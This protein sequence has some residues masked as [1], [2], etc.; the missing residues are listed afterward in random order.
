MKKFTAIVCLIFALVMA[1]ALPV[2]A[3]SPY[4]TY[5]YSISGKALHSPDAYTPDKTVDSMGM[6]LDDLDFIG[7]YYP[8]LY[9]LQDTITAC[10]I[11]AEKEQAKFYAAW[12]KDSSQYP[13]SEAV[14]YEEFK[15]AQDSLNKALD[16]VKKAKT[17]YKTAMDTYGK[18][19]GPSD[20]EVDDNDNVYI[21]DTTNNRIVVLDRY[22]KAKYIITSFINAQGTMDALKTP[23]G[24]FI[25]SDKYVAGELVPGKIY[26]CDSGN[27][28]IVTFNRNGE[29]LEIIPQPE[30]EL[31]G[32]DSVYTP[33]AVAV[34]NY[35]RLYVVSS[36]STDGIIV[37]TDEGEFT[38]FVGAQKVTVSAWE[39]LWE[40]FQTEA[41]KEQDAQKV[42]SAFNNITLTGDFIYVTTSSIHPE[43]VTSAIDS[44]STSGDYAPVKMLNAAGDE[45][46]RR[47]GFYPPSGEVDH[48][49]RKASNTIF[50]ASTVVDVAI[51]P[52]KTWSI[53]DQKRSKVF[54]YDFDGN[55]LFAFGDMGAESQMQLGNIPNQA[56]AGIVYQG[57]KML[58]LNK[59]DNNFTVY[60]RT[61]Y[62]NILIRALANQNA[63]QNDKAIE[64]WTEILKRNSNFDAA[65]IGIGKALYRSGDYEES[66]EYFKSAY[67]TANYSES[68]KEIRKEW[69]S[70]FIILVPIF[71]VV[72]CIGLAKFFGFAKK[73]N[74]R[75]SVTKGKRT[76]A[77][78]LM[79][80]F[81]VMFHPFDGF[82]DLK[83]EKRGSARAG[84][85][86]LGVTVVAF[87]YQSLGKGYIM[88]ARGTYMTFFGAV[89]AV[90]VPLALWI[91][92]NWCL[93]TLFE[94]EGS[95]KDIFIATTYS[96]PPLVLVII[97]ATIAS[98]F[99]LA[100]EASLISVITVFG[101][102]WA[103]FLLFFGMMVT[104]D[105][106]MG[107]NL[108]MTLSTIVGMVCIMFIALLFSTLLGKLVSFI[109][110]IVT[111]IQYRM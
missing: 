54:T 88:N 106:T 37:M 75:V 23:Q 29:F 5:T 19:N 56:L 95:L 58:L 25:T 35:D 20:I 26:V 30:S 102:V 96:L 8:E 28:R 1:L 38:G 27:N 24:V 17:N 92:A 39:K 80:M 85:T 107:K 98:N 52:E 69:L 99:V 101:F 3:A 63:R 46:M 2:A 18:I 78:E 51:G 34:D 15:A 32:T 7:Q 10:E 103:G 66:L 76:Y 86:I 83:H 43:Q 93:T 70:K 61:E 87:W 89:M 67:D 12:G 109:T 49:M 16:S 42:S 64:D 9:P 22:Y 4:Q 65:Y 111:E 53:I 79:Y 11:A 33:I 40:R 74:K 13:N 81:H 59:N 57:D 94:G 60:S 90:V 36:T 105:Y 104:H 91:I 45:I 47:N 71:V 73:F 77:Q 44:K 50:G 14:E 108:I 41:Q 72:V 82:W 110:N 100:N 48:K 84:L 6:G 21:A 62:G 97:P 55:L 68:Y 31:F